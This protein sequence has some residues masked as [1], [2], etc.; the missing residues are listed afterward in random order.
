[1]GPIDKLSALDIERFVET[2]ARTQ[3][4][5]NDVDG[6]M[7]Y[8]SEWTKGGKAVTNPAKSR[9]SMPVFDMQAHDITASRRAAAV[10]QAAA[11]AALALGDFDDF[12]DP[13]KPGTRTPRIAKPPGALG[14]PLL[15]FLEL[16]MQH[17]GLNVGEDRALADKR[18]EPT[19]KEKTAANNEANNQ[20][21]INAPGM[22][23][24]LQ[25]LMSR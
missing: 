16:L 23:Q 7:Q 6:V 25:L 5:I 18:N 1:M 11:R 19:P 17:T 3:D 10:E 22:N 4:T 9:A 15:I 20:A 13:K 14:V 21:G 12:G 24:L 2:L 8:S